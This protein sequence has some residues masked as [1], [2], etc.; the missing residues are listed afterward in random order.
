MTPP[1]FEND[2]Q[3]IRILCFQSFRK[4]VLYAGS[5]DGVYDNWKLS[6]EFAKK[7]GMFPIEETEGGKFL[8]EPVRK[9][10][11]DYPEHKLPIIWVRSSIKYCLNIE[12]SVKTFVCGARKQSIFRKKEIQALLRARGVEDINGQPLEYYRSIRQGTSNRLRE[13][14]KH[15]PPSERLSGREMHHAAMTAVFIAIAENEVAQDYKAAIKTRDNAGAE[16]VLMRL[17]YLQDRRLVAEQKEG[18]KRR[19]GAK[20]APSNDNR[21]ETDE[22]LSELYRANPHLRKLSGGYSFS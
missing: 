1:T 18:L 10:V 17:T 8:S 14:N 5:E 3:L 6:S 19:F 21:G 2:Y 15:L 22:A 20:A 4:A 7:N 16:N 13:N 12:G 9:Y 11:K